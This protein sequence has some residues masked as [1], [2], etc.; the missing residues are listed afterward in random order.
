MVYGRIENK[1]LSFKSFISISL[2]WATAVFGQSNNLNSNKDVA[3]NDSYIEDNDAQSV[4]NDNTIDGQKKFVND[5]MSVAGYK[6]DEIIV[7]QNLPNF[8]KIFRV[9]FNEETQS[10]FIFIRWDKKKKENYVANKMIDPQIYYNLK[11]A[12]EIMRQQTD[13][14]AFNIDDVALQAPDQETLSAEDLEGLRQEYDLKQEEKKLKELEKASNKKKRK[15][16]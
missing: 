11:V 12:K 2:F 10:G 5:L 14:K 8:A 7:Y 4:I 6:V 1:S 9:I 15:K 3:N 16:N 13:K